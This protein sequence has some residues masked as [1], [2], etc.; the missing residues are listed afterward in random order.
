ME[1][2][3][4][5]EDNKKIFKL[6]YF[7]IAIYA[8]VIFYLN[9]MNTGSY[10]LLYSLFGATVALLMSIMVLLIVKRK[11][12]MIEINYEENQILFYQSTY[13]KNKLL[14][15]LIVLF[16][17]LGIISLAGMSLYFYFKMNFVKV[18]DFYGLIVLGAV[19]IFLLVI[20]IK[21]IIKV[22]QIDRCEVSNSIFNLYSYDKKFLLAFVMLLLA[23]FNIGIISFDIPHFVVEWV[24]LLIFEIIGLATTLIYVAGLYITSKYYSYYSFKKVDGLNIDT[25]ILE[26]IG[27]GQFASVYK[28]Y[29]P[30]LDKV[31]AVKK[32]ESKEVTDIARFENE[33]K[34]MK[35]LDHQNLVGVYS[36]N[37]VKLEYIMDYIDFNLYDYI[38]SH[39]ISTE[40]RIELIKQLLDGMEYLHTHNILHRDLS[41][42][43]VMIKQVSG[44]EI[45]LKITDFGLAK[46]KLEATMTKTKTQTSSTFLDPTLSSFKNFTV[47]ND[48]YALGAVINFIYYG[49]I[50]VNNDMSLI[51]KIVFKCMDL[52][53]DNRYKNISEIKEELSKGLGE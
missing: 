17:S 7:V 11:R 35:S 45:K 49:D 8:A 32:L 21:D 19:A 30:S 52:S 26:C 42:G 53:L 28:V 29:I 36:Y 27:K 24:D 5:R 3:R 1:K 16:D 40:L 41:L 4:I 25:Q 6:V 51:S 38:N 12:N 34:L 43:N 31:L 23:A 13:E 18:Y 50:S 20:L 44:D 48:I 39:A 33:F 37:E 22:T 47:Q 46:N 10:V 9:I 2:R 15:M 14:K